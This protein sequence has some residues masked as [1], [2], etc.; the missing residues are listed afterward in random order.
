[1]T[2]LEELVTQFKEIP[3]Y[4]RYPLPEVFY[5]KFGLKKPKPAE[6]I[7]PVYLPPPSQ[8]LNENGKIEERGPAEGGVREIKD[9][10]VLPIEVKRLNDETGDLEDY[11]PPRQLTSLSFEDSLRTMMAQIKDRISSDTEKDLSQDSLNRP[12]EDNRTETPLVLDL[13]SGGLSC[14]YPYIS[15][16]VP[17]PLS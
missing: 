10:Q 12:K 3:D 8:S 5:Q 1:M 14:A 4:E 9:L 2:T 7:T 16:A 11:P 6:S 17:R 13:P 15:S